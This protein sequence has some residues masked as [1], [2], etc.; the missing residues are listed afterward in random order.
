MAQLAD[1]LAPGSHLA[2]AHI[3]TEFFPDKKA[4]ARAIKVYESA[5]EQI[6]PRSREQILALFDG[7]ELLDPGIVP[8]DEW[9]PDRVQP[10]AEAE[11]A[12]AADTPNIQWGAGGR[13]H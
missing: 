10:E 13:K 3:G 11:A 5:S 1:A 2:V 7:F 8:K 4:L 12:A 9:R 6:H